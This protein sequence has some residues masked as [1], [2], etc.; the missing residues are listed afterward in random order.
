MKAGAP[1]Q[2]RRKPFAGAKPEGAEPWMSRSDA[3]V[4]WQNVVLQNVS[5]TGSRGQPRAAKIV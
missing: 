4:R 2:R 3:N 5:S 1:E